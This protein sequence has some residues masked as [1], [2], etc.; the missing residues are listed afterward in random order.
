MPPNSCS[1]QKLRQQMKIDAK[2]SLWQS[3]KVSLLPTP[4]LNFPDTY[5]ARQQ[6]RAYFL[7]SFDSYQSLFQC[8]K[9]DAAYYAKP[10]TA[11]YPL[12][13]YFGYTATFFVHKLLLSQLIREQINPELE[14]I[15]TIKDDD[16]SGDDFSNAHTRWPTI[17]EVRAYRDRIRALILKLIEHAPLN[18]PLNEQNPW[19]AII[20]AIEHERIHL[21][22]CAALI[23]QHD[24]QYIHQD[25]HWQADIIS[26]D[27]PTNQLLTIPAARLHLNKKNSPN[28]YAWDNE[29]AVH[30]AEVDAFKASQ[31]L[32]SN[33]EFLS[34][35]EAEGYHQAEYWNPEGLAWRELSQAQHPTFWHRGKE[36]WTL[37]IMLE[38]I[39]M[40][41]DW[42]VEVNYHEANAFC[43]WK[44]AQSG[45]TVRLLTED[46]WYRLYAVSDLDPN[47]PS[48]Q[49]ANIELKYARSP[50]PVH[51]FC[52]GDFYDVQGNVW[53]WTET[54]MYPFD[55]FQTHPIYTGFSTP[56]FDGRHNLVKGGSWISAGNKA[57]YSAHHA[58]PR[59]CVQHA[60]FR[61]AAAADSSVIEA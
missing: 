58:L 20:M 37:R 9:N 30:E 56:S 34:F 26:A 32:V 7:N 39:A 23:R 49:Y 8:L 4:D 21:E 47:L 35:V 22:T 6:L 24:L 59:D 5:S 33:Q 44:S 25:P 60:G 31:F 29:Y 43:Q 38:N 45:Q 61:Y 53:Q 27:A 11:H 16:I 3:S 54:P 12:I 28:F 17:N 2:P 36:G 48:P 18:L 52:H 14:S 50:C 57:L 13:F 55:G 40:P 51:I 19:W 10:T 41:W 1:A 42:P 46:E 15:F